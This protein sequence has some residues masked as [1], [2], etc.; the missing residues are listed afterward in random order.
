[1]WTTWWWAIEK[2]ERMEKRAKERYRPERP[3]FRLAG[4]KIGL[5]PAA[6]I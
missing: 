6:I 1:M 3:K 2:D 4:I 5:E